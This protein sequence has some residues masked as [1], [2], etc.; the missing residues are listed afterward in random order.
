ML[1]L[2]ITVDIPPLFL[3]L[4][5]VYLLFYSMRRLER[6]KLVSSNLCLPFFDSA[7]QEQRGIDGKLGAMVLWNRVSLAL[8]VPGAL[9]S[10]ATRPCGKHLYARVAAL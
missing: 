1:P 9:A 4:A 2:L 7:E 3:G 8:I 6:I 10:G 5:L